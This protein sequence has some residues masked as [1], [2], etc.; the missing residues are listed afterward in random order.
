MR[1]VKQ[2][3]RDMPV[4]LK[5][6]EGKLKELPHRILMPPDWAL[7]S[8][9]LW[10]TGFSK[11]MIDLMPKQGERYDPLN[12]VEFLGCFHSMV[13]FVSH[14]S[15]AQLEEEKALPVEVSEMRQQLSGKLEKSFCSFAVNLA[16]R[17]PK[18]D[19]L[20]PAD[21]QRLVNERYN[22]G[23]KAFRARRNDLTG[24]MN[25]TVT[26]YHVVWMFWPAL[27]D[28]FTAPYIHSW[29]KRELTCGESY[30]ES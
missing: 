25:S 18:K 4:E 8:A 16:K 19:G 14:P 21:V 30:F 26:L 28:N 1:I 15:Q 20:P 7:A 6:A 9:R 22:K 29:F 2:R 27:K 17:L 3:M 10:S 11:P 24:F 12:I 23:L 13:S 5:F